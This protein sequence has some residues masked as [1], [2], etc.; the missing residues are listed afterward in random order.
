MFKR[1]LVSTSN[2]EGLVDFLRPFTQQG[3]EVVSTGG[4]SKFLKDNGIKVTEVS[5]VTGFPEMM[6]GRIRTLHPYIHMALLARSFVPEDFEILK[7]HNVK[8]FDLVVVNLYPFAEAV[9]KNLKG[10]ELIEQ[11]D[12]G[13]PS[14]LRAAAKSF[15]RIAVVCEPEDY[16]NVLERAK[17]NTL[18]KE[19]KQKLAAKVFSHCA[20]YDALIANTLSVQEINPSLPHQSQINL[21][22]KKE[23]RYGENPHQ[24]A[25]FYDCLNPSPLSLH[26]AEQ[27]QG[28]ELSYNNLLDLESAVSVLCEFE[29]P[30]SVIIKHNTPCGVAEAD[31]ILNSY[32]KAFSGDPVSAFGGVVALNKKV[33]AALAQKMVEPFLECIIAPDFEAAALE[34]FKTK[35]NLRILKLKSLESSFGTYEKFDFKNMRGGALVQTTDQLLQWGPSWKVVGSK[36]EDST[37]KADL[38]FAMRVAKH[39]KSNAIVIAANSQTI[40]VCGGQT[41]RIDSV[42]MALARARMFGAQFNTWSLASDAFFP[43]RDSVD[44][45]AT[46]PVK[47]IIQPGGSLKD[48]EVEAAVLEHK[49]GMVVTGIRHFKH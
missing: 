44:I 23:L 32:E 48:P 1:A 27:L 47:W 12:I 25:G 4:T 8:P 33:T 10:Q 16:S 38:L 36:L 39:V 41:N 17:N 26:H 7:Q 28:K 20:K 22:L 13:G 15:E 37:I 2:K 46:Y 43:F 21:T 40:G 35:K 3:M 11:I 9:K 24:K 14:L 19:F 34:V 45:A 29:K 31:N 30:S 49:M 6:D 18:D 5:D 42:K